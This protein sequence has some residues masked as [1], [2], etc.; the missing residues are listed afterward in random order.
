MMEYL[1]SHDMLMLWISLYGSWALFVLLALGILALPVP[2]ETLM[3]LAGILMRNGD[4]PM[5]P[6][7]VA[8]YAGAVCGITMSYGVGRSIGLYLITRYGSKIGLSQQRLEMVH[9]WFERFGKWTLFFGYFVPGVRH[10]TGFIA[11]TSYLHYGAFALFAYTGAFAWVSTFL[12]IGYFL[13]E[14]GLAIF[15]TMEGFTDE[16]V[17]LLIIAVVGYAFWWINSR[18]K[19]ST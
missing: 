9:Q 10:F 18:R 6:T 3:I 4:L 2:E 19:K 16:I 1:P 11:G 7:I 12:S 5:T 13:G 17:T 14:Y 15:K 8:S